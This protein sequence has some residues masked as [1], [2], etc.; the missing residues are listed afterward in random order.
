MASE[1]TKTDVNASPFFRSS[2]DF[3]RF[4][5]TPLPGDPETLDQIEDSATTPGA[6]DKGPIAPNRPARLKSLD[7]FRGLTILGMLFVNNTAGRVPEW[8]K[9]GDWTGAVNLADLVFPWFLFIVGV[10]LPYSVASARRIH[11]PQCQFDLK[12]L[13]RAL[14]L[15]TLG[16]IIDSFLAHKP[17]FDLDV[18]QLIGLAYFMA[19]LIGGLFRLPGR[20]VLAGLLLLAN[21]AILMHVPIPGHGAGHFTEEINVPKY[22]NETYLSRFHLNGLLSVIPTTALVL[23][24][25]IVGDLLRRKKVNS[26]LKA[27]ILFIC[28]A[29]MVAAGYLWSHQALGEYALPMNKPSWSASYILFCGGW[30]CIGLAI[31]YL[32]V[33]TTPGKWGAKL[34]FPLIVFGMNAIVAYV[35]PILTKVAILRN[36]HSTWP[37]GHSLNL[38]TAIIR[39][40]EL[41]YGD[42]KGGLAYTLTY[43]AL[44]WCVLLFLYRK[45]W[46]LRV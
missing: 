39:S 10:A 24:G 33:D 43:I 1:A 45:R 27:G 15:I 30:A 34:T 9:H 11:L 37:T 28:G 41:K 17:L 16:C 19:V 35:L 40:F 21:W 44:W 6:A 38:E 26:F 46:F 18:L 8:A 2:V 3:G 29:G 7:A 22:V 25:T 20:I 32:L 23:I 14:S 12:A 31:T 13:W 5:G 36:I 42:I 4:P